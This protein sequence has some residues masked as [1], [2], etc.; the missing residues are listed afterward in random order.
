[1]EQAVF[2]RLFLQSD[3]YYWK[4]HRLREIDFV[5][6]KLEQTQK[7]IQVT[8]AS[9]LPEISDREISNLISAH[10]KLGGNMQIITWDLETDLK[11]GISCVP[12]Y[13]FLLS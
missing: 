5:T 9:S 10:S 13:K 4:D 11:N 2:S 12:L 1:M 8:Y 6:R 3:I 7:L